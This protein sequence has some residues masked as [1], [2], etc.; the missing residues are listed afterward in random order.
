MGLCAYSS[1][2]EGI[3][4]N[5]DLKLSETGHVQSETEKSKIERSCHMMMFVNGEERA[6]GLTQNSRC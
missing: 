2:E 5:V 1:F 6:T 4:F 3:T